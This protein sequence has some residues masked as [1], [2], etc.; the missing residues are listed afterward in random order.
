[1]IGEA[2]RAGIPGVLV[3]MGG[4][5]FPVAEQ[6]RHHL[7]CFDNAMKALRM[8][9]GRPLRHERYTMIG[10]AHFVHPGEGGLFRKRRPGPTLR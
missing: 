3:E 10:N 6:V 5:Q 8:I 4:G 9:D 1:M 7:T 2:S